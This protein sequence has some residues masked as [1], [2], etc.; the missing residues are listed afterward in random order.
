VRHQGLQID[1]ENRAWELTLLSSAINSR[2]SLNWRLLCPGRK[3]V[4]RESK[5]V[6]KILKDFQLVPPWSS[7]VHQQHIAYRI[8]N[9]KERKIK[10]DPISHR[11]RGRESISKRKIQEGLPGAETP[12]S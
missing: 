8:T 9:F 1:P 4:Y 7:V 3:Q 12:S 2:N 6:S 11:Q 5:L 10:Q